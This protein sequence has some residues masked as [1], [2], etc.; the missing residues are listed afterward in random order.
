[1]KEDNTGC[2]FRNDVVSVLAVRI[3]YGCDAVVVVIVVVGYVFA[4]LGDDCRA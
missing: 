3:V 4:V 1:M 2:Y